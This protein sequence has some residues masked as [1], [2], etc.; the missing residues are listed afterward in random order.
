MRKRNFNK[1]QLML[2]VK[3]HITAFGIYFST[4]LFAVI[5]R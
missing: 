4:V 2:T 1:D 3:T 5:M